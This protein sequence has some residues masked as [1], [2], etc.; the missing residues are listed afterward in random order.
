M[1][2]LT[3]GRE[4][5][6]SD[7]GRLTR[8]KWS[9]PGKHSIKAS[10][11]GPICLSHAQEETVTCLCRDLYKGG[12]EAGGDEA[13]QQPHRFPPWNSSVSQQPQ[14]ELNVPALEP[15]L[16]PEHTL[17]TG[18][19]LLFWTYAYTPVSSCKTV[20]RLIYLLLQSLTQRLPKRRPL[21]LLWKCHVRELMGKVAYFQNVFSLVPTYDLTFLKEQLVQIYFR[22]YT[23]KN[24]DKNGEF[25]LS[26]FFE[27]MAAN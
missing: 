6:T 16:D 22:N 3:T 13:H 9:V 1:V 24:C 15:W 20:S 14:A 5:W 12:M 26:L 19:L 10:S 11:L 4:E 25:I 23:S 7:G 2:L 21:Q 27:E 18:H 8:R 17:A